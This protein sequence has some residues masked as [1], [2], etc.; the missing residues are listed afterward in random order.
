M[1][2][3]PLLLGRFEYPAC[4]TE[5]VA[6]ELRQ[7]VGGRLKETKARA[8]CLLRTIMCPCKPTRSVL[9]GRAYRTASNTLAMASLPYSVLLRFAIKFRCSCVYK[10][11]V[12]S[13][14]HAGEQ[15][16]RLLCRGGCGGLQDMGTCASE[17]KKRRLA[18][19][20]AE[21]SLQ[22]G[23]SETPPSCSA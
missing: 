13:T 4:K 15:H 20:L 10:I 22:G 2:P 17:G 18:C 6:R 9:F 8:V 14:G 23:T 11:G 7:H 5:V 16:M 19:S 12:H 3:H 1:Y 21:V